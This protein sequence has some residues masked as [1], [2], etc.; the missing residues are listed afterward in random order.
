MNG[1]SVKVYS[2]ANDGGKQVSAHFKVREFQCHAKS[3]TVFI[4]DA[5][6][7]VLEKIRA[8]FGKPVHINSGYRC[9]ALNNAVGGKASSQHLRGEAADI[10]TGSPQSNKQLYDL[11][12]SL[13]LPIDQLIGERGYTWLHISH[14]ASGYNRHQY[15]AQ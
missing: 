12:I 15:W 5:Q 13:R 9:P 11:A 8:H 4:S 3:D 10:T 14:K 6:I 1:A 7:A 2:V